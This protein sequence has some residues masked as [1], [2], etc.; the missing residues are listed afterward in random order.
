MPNLAQ[1]ILDLELQLKNIREE[2]LGEWKDEK[3]WKDLEKTVLSTKEK[4]AENFG[5]SLHR[6]GNFKPEESIVETVVKKFPDAMKIRSKKKNRLP[7]HACVRT[8]IQCGAPYIPLLAR[9]GTKH[10]VGGEEKRG[11]LLTLDPSCV[12]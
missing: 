7:I 3:C 11:G 9:E 12:F 10:D 6:L 1:E 2:I 8:R 4:L 5:K